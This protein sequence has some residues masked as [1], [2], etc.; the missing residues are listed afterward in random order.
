VIQKREKWKLV[1]LNHTAPTMRGL[2]KVHKDGTPIRPVV[3]WRNAPVYK[4]AQS[5]V[6]KLTSYI[7]LP[8]TYNIKN[9]VQLMDDVIEIPQ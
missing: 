2:I 6:R 5:L 1:N 8:F 9:T 3:N 4:L 7:P